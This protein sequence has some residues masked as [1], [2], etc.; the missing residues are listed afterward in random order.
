[1]YYWRIDSI[2]NQ[3]GETT[4]DSWSF[5]TAASTSP[6]GP[7]INPSPA[8]GSSGVELNPILSW[9]AGSQATSHDVY[10]GTST[11]LTLVSGNQSETSWAPAPDSLNPNT[12]YH[13]R[14]DEKNAQGVTPGTQWSFT[15]RDLAPVDTVTI[16]KAEWRSKRNRLIVEA[17]S[18]G[19]PDAVLTVDGNQMSFNANKNVYT[20]QQGSVSSNPQ[21][22][23][24]DSSLGG[25]QTSSVDTRN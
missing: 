11:S 1:M 2:N 22:V 3:G 25:T 14:V 7:A 15:T 21:T 19:A 13:W 18:D 9:T 5:T 6:P 8:D 16:T 17:T 20:Y 24:V 23:T 12:T 10:F 4:G